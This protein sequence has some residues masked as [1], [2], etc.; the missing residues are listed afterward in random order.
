M[1]KESILAN[2]DVRIEADDEAHR[3]APRG[4]ALEVG[5]VQFLMDNGE[6]VQH[7][8]IER[9]RNS[10]KKALLPFDQRY[11]RMVVVRQVSGNPAM[12]RVYVK[13]A[14][15]YVIPLCS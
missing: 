15:E 1:I 13:G 4:Q 6:D 14:P 11:R 3:Y 9:N 8:M 7:L 2:T 5:L 12:S 10:P